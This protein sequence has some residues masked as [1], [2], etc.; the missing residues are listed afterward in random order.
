MYAKPMF[1]FTTAA[2]EP[3]DYQGDSRPARLL[4]FLQHSI[5]LPQSSEPKTHIFTCVTWPMTHPNQFDVGQPVEVW[6]DNLDE[7]DSCNFLL[8]VTNFTSRVIFSLDSLFG[9]NVLVV[10]PV[11]D[12]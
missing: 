11:I 6:C 4:H 10:V 9:S 5:V 12:H 8:P 7:P 1:M 2:R 3:T